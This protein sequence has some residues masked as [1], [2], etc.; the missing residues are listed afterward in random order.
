MNEDYRSLS[1]KVFDRLEEDILSGNYKK[2][3]TLKEKSLSAPYTAA[4]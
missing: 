4:F 2:G 3:E 1:D